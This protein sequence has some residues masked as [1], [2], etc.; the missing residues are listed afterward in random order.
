M[1]MN[2]RGGPGSWMWKKLPKLTQGLPRPPGGAAAML[3]GSDDGSSGFRETLVAKREREAAAKAEQRKRQAKEQRL[4]DLRDEFRTESRQGAS[5]SIFKPGKKSAPDRQISF[6]PSKP[7]SPGAQQS[8]GH[9]PNKHSMTSDYDPKKGSS[10]S[11]MK[12]DGPLD[13]GKSRKGHARVSPQHSKDNSMSEVREQA[14]AAYR[15]L[16]A[17]QNRSQK[18]V[19]AGQRR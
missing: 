6:S 4:A 17:Q 16:R 15:L 12:A 9:S 8:G 19:E 3:R 5:G 11:K 2:D 10:L 13:D 7:S 18:M 1:V 14:L